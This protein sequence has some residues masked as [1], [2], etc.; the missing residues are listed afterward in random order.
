QTSNVTGQANISSEVFSGDL[1][2]GMVRM[3]YPRVPGR[4]MALSQE[5]GAS[6]L[7]GGMLDLGGENRTAFRGELSW[8]D[9]RRWF[10][11]GKMYLL[12]RREYISG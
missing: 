9:G 11:A 8:R 3:H 4:Y 10:T 12:R 5:R 6:N 2:S 7:R 1:L